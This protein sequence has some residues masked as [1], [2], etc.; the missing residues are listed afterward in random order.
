MFDMESPCAICS[1][2]H[3]QEDA[4]VVMFPKAWAH[5]PCWESLGSEDV[6]D[7]AKKI[8]CCISAQTVRLLGGCIIQ[9]NKAVAPGTVWFADP[10]TG[11]LKRFSITPEGRFEVLQDL[12]RDK[13]GDAS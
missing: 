8:P 3:N 4:R 7:I 11:V 9:R 6:W 10:D 12:K 5:V 2:G 1:R 13:T